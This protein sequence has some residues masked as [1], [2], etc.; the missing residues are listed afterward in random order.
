MYSKVK[1]FG[2]PIHPMLIAFP[3]GLYTATFVAFLIFQIGGDPFWFRVGLA[4]NV[5]GVIMAV[6]AALFGF[7]DWALGIPGGTAAKSDGLK[8]MA[9]NVIALILFVINLI[10]FLGQ[11]AVPPTSALLAVILTL[12][13][14]LVTVGAG[15][16]GWT[17]IQFHHVGVEL[18]P[19]QARLEPAENQPKGTT[20]TST[21]AH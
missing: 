12:V 5:A 13:G 17:L 11:W 21:Y 8:H 4:A 20:S 6:L 16:F 18:T 15:F 19:E 9:L 1:L 2:H 14:V 7:L 3:V 10:V